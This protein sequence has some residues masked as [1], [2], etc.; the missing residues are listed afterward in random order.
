MKS[1]FFHDIALV[2]VFAT[3]T[4]V[5]P[6][7]LYAQQALTR[8]GYGL[9]DDDQRIP[10]AESI[11]IAAA[12]TEQLDVLFAAVHGTVSRERSLALDQ[13][14]MLPVK[15]QAQLLARLFMDDNLLRRGEDLP[16]A[17]NGASYF[18]QQRLQSK[19]EALAYAIFREV[20][21][22]RQ[23]WFTRAQASALSTRLNAVSQ[24]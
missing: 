13:I 2:F 7:R 3:I 18:I 17:S 4:L 9:F 15:P 14:G 1:K 10:E 21:P 12:K 11:I 22:T 16:G 8:S 6:L 24:N 19:L 5:S 23:K 20:P